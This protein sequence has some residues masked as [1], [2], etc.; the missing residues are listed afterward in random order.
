MNLEKL[1]ELMS[2]GESDAQM[3]D[4]VRYYAD[5]LWTE[6]N[7]Y[8]MNEVLVMEN[9]VKELS[10]VI[11]NASIGKKY[12]AEVFIPCEEMTDTS[13]SG[14]TEEQHGLQIEKL[15]GEHS[16]RISGSPKVSGT[17]DLVLQYRFQG[18]PVEHACLERTLQIIINPD[19]RDLWKDVPVPDGIEYPKENTAKEYLKIQS[20]P[21]GTPQKDMVAASKR[22]RSHAQEGKP[23]DDHFCLYHDDVTNWYVMAVADG[24]GSACYSR[25]G[26]K[27]ACETAVR[28]CKEQ[29]SNSA[30]FDDD[31]TL[32][33]LDQKSEA[34]G[35]A[36][37]ADIYRIV[38]NAAL[39]A[40][41]AI[42][43]EA[44]RKERKVKDYSTTLLLAICKKFDFGW[45]IASFWVGD[46]AICLYDEKDETA[47]MLGMPDEGEYAG[48]TRFLTMP[49]IFTDTARF[50]QRMNCRIVREFTALFLMTDGVSDPMFETDANLKS[51]AKWNMLWHTLRSN[52]V[53]LTDDNEDAA[54]QLLQWLDFWSPGNH[55]DR[56]IAILY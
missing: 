21:D 35:Q 55:D 17:F 34:A 42:A 36:I 44:M 47:I 19:P 8:V 23:R 7:E 22:G 50:Y 31:I 15:Q 18:L 13:L 39:K 2:N 16:F 3:E 46:G 5:K 10:I 28:H 24:A 48:Q 9:K 52:G 26:A 11:P 37:S 32:Y 40:H 43:A 49:E 27:I 25:E 1:L 6:Y 33:H 51:Y 45:F 41:K 29:L 12:D 14:L 20:L 30:G 54:G 56:T 4:F 38:G 53:E